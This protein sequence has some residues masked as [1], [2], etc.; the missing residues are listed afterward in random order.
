VVFTAHYYWQ[1]RYNAD[2]RTFNPSQ[3]TGAYGLLD[4]RA[5]ITGIAGTKFDFGVYMSNV[6]NTPVCMP[7]YNGVLN[8]APN[9]TFGIANTA[10]A[11]QCVPLAPRMSGITL[12]YK[13]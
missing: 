9:S 6:I 4:L 2:L 3:R 5:D 10:G 8:S 12:G 11:L 13:F 1:S 7:E